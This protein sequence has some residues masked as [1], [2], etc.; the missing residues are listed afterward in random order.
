MSEH[1]LEELHHDEVKGFKPAFI[2][3]AICFA[4]YLISMFL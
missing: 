1:N 3:L 4:V 2:I